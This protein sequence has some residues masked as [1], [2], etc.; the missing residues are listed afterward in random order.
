[1]RRPATAWRQSREEAI[2]DP[3]RKKLVEPRSTSVLLSTQQ[4]SARKTLRSSLSG[5]P[6]TGPLCPSRPDCDCGR[7]A[8]PDRRASVQLIAMAGRQPRSPCELALHNVCD[9][10]NQQAAPSNASG[11]RGA[12]SRRM[13]ERWGRLHNVRSAL[14][15]MTVLLFTYESLRL[16]VRFP[17]IADIRHAPPPTRSG[18]RTRTNM[19]PIRHFNVGSV[20]GLSA[21]RP[22]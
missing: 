8:G 3:I 12:E 2:I 11:G 18:S 9:H 21:T 15:A 16:G 14:G 5:S 4:V 19:G 10:A 17:R 22:R 20:P 13:L 6:A 1:M 7:R